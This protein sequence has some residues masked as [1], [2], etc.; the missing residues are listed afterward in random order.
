M[1]KPRT[2]E[3]FLEL[4]WAARGGAQLQDL[5]YDNIKHHLVDRGSRVYDHERITRATA[6][7][8]VTTT[9]FNDKA[10]L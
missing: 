6:R 10:R 4:F 9:V 5:E 3:V 7:E 2:L 1:Q 8:I